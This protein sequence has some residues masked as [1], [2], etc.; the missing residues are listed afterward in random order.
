MSKDN[1]DMMQCSKSSLFALRQETNNVSKCFQSARH[2]FNPIWSSN[3]KEHKLQK[4]L[5]HSISLI[6]VSSG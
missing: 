4:T 1:N 2:L 6:E 5:F 3:T